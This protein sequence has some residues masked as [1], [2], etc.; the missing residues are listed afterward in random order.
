MQPE[1]PPVPPRERETITRPQV[2]DELLEQI[3][4]EGT[5]VEDAPVK[6][7]SNKRRWLWTSFAVLLVFAVFAVGAAYVWYKDQLSSPAPGSQETA[8]IVVGDGDTSSD[9]AAK[10]IEDKVIKNQFAFELYYRLNQASGLKAGVYIV[11]R[12]ASV[13]DI[14]THLEEGKSDEFTLTFLPGA[15]LTDAK[16]VLLAAG[17]NETEIESAFGADYDHP[18][19]KGKPAE[20]DLEGYI[21][22]DTYNFFTGST[23]EDVLTKLFDHMYADIEANNLEAAYAAQGM[24]LYEGIIFASIVQGEVANKS[25]MAHVSQVFHKRLDIDMVLGSDVTFIYGARKLG[26]QPSVDLDSPYNTRVVPGLTPTPVSNPGLDALI[27]GANPSDTD[28]LY[29]VSGDDGVTYF[30]ETN[31]EHERLTRE[32]CQANCL[33][34]AR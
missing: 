18:L 15:T 5:G 7:R 21:Y 6:K 26:V 32:H 30:S 24:S 11:D 2:S 16:Q 31:E 12:S 9:V 22:G 1:R 19:L 8:R 17:Y 28:D 10:L 25:E 34:P 3:R 14:V 27:A 29:F 4:S 33:L 23:V 20:A 13:Q